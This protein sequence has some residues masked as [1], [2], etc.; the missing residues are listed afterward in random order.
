MDGLSS[1]ASAFAVVSLAAQVASGIQKLCDFWQSVRDGPKDVLCIVRDLEVVSIILDEMRQEAHGER[2]HSRAL[3]TTI[4]ALE[5]CN[6]S[7]AAL[8][9]LIDELQP[10]FTSKK[11]ALKKR[12]ALKAAWKG[13][14]IRKFRETLKDM[15]LTLLL[16]KQNS[17]EHSTTIRDNDRQLDLE[18]I[19]HGMRLLLMQKSQT[20]N[21]MAST[22]SLNYKEHIQAL[23]EECQ[24]MSARIANP[25]G[26]YGAQSLTD[27][28]LSE[29]SAESA[30]DKIEDLVQNKL[31][32]PLPK[33]TPAVKYSRVRAR[34]NF[35]I[36]GLFGTLHM[37]SSVITNVTTSSTSVAEEGSDDEGRSQLQTIITIHP[38]RWLST[39]GLMLG[40]Q[41]IMSQSLRGL[42]CRARTYR[43]VPDD[44]RVF[45]L[46][47]SGDI[48]MIQ[49]LF[50]RG[51]ASPWDTDSRGLTPLF[52]AARA[53]QLDVCKLL[54]NQGADVDARTLT[55]DSVASY[56]C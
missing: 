23:R 8:N 45:S 10:G 46:C 9:H 27:S 13:D 55:N 4:E 51:Q 35:A 32:V 44:S 14:M 19:A 3:A 54:I 40:I 2:P 34:G 53:R 22:N 28:A 42:D 7:V 47:R 48:D 50:D 24:I 36:T 26:R 49:Q 5:S 56:A 37:T 16:A 15:K 17:I 20:M 11:R 41:I 1:A 18:A 29:F 25:V 39:I 52:F 30:T 31:R 38:S 12:A 33:K 43:A 6:G 21:A